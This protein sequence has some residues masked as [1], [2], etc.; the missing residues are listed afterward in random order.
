M[1]TNAK[2]GRLDQLTRDAAQRFQ[3]RAHDEQA[4]EVHLRLSHARRVQRARGIHEGAPGQRRGAA[5][6]CF[7]L[8]ALQQRSP[9]EAS[10]SAWLCDRELDHP[11]RRSPLSGSAAFSESTARGRPPFWRFFSGHMNPGL[12]QD[13]TEL[14][15]DGCRKR[16][17]TEHTISYRKG[18]ALATGSS[19]TMSH[20]LLGSPNARERLHSPSLM[21]EHPLPSNTSRACVIRSGLGLRA[22]LLLGRPRQRAR[23]RCRSRRAR[24]SELHDHQSASSYRRAK[25]TTPC[26]SRRASAPTIA[27]STRTR[28][29]A[30]A[31]SPTV[32]TAALTARASST[33]S[34]RSSRRVEGLGHRQRHQHR[35][36]R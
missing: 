28:S 21:S 10:E 7:F 22:R 23:S 33:T 35:R 11:P 24:A 6:S 18:K 27:S 32:P 16:H 15:E 14:F 34:L 3:R 29:R 8:T 12:D 25:K 31:T 5:C 1:T 17:D 9:R 20:H 4:L 30:P 13:R 26:A 36:S 2:A 19:Q